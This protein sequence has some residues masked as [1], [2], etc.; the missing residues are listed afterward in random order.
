MK[1]RCLVALHK[2]LTGT[3][4]SANIQY[5]VLLQNF[6]YILCF[7]EFS[8]YAGL[9]EAAKQQQGLFG[10]L[11]RDVVSRFCKMYGQA[12]PVYKAVKESVLYFFPFDLPIIPRIVEIIEADYI[13]FS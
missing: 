3:P 5:L 11:N 4:A 8:A 12:E 2:L 13:S 7:R 6:M 1:G 10:H 9:A